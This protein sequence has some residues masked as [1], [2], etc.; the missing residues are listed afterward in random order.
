[1]AGG[2]LD[3]DNALKLGLALGV[4]NSNLTTD[5]GATS[6]GQSFDFGAALNYS[7]G[8]I[9]LAAA[10]SGGHGT[11]ASE[12][13]VSFDGFTDNLTLD[14]SHR[15]FHLECRAIVPTLWSTQGHL[16]TRSI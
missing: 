5:A 8:P 1:M 14:R 6:S 2:Q 12:R 4:S 10:L 13:D 16:L 11:F 3:M 7:N 15:R 9:S